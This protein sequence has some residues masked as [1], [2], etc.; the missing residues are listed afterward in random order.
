MIA[1]AVVGPSTA[2]AG[3]ADKIQQARGNVTELRN[4]VQ[5]KVE[6]IQEKIEDVDSEA[7]EQ[8]GEMVQSMFEFVKQI[9]AGYKEFV[10][11]D[12]CG[13]AS[14]GVF[15]TQL[16]SLMQGFL[17]LP[18]EL[19]F[20]EHV[21]PAVRQLEQMVKLVDFLPPVILFASEK[22]LGNAF[23]EIRYRIELVRYAAS[24]APRLPTMDELS[25]AS[26]RS[27]TA[28]V[29]TRGTNQTLTRT[30]TD[31]DPSFPYCTA[32]LDTGK[33]HIELLKQ[34]LNTWVT[35]CGTWP[36]PWKKTRPWALLRARP[37]A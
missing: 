32:I 20:V 31:P 4:T 21:P 16:R 24:Q 23:E 22:V 17:A 19:Q 37:P 30:T 15:R 12:K 6:N 18:S 2:S 25:Q 8:V 33:P 1:G 10:G 9:Q 7:L 27:A 34:P 29:S 26:A 11:A 14:C 13:T 36:T 28:Q 35:S 3:L 5:G